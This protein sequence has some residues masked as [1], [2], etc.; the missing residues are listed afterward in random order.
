MV[1]RSPE[2]M[3]RMIAFSVLALG[4][5]LIAGVSVGVSASKTQNVKRIVQNA[6]RTTSKAVKIKGVTINVE[7]ADTAAAR[8]R[9]LSGRASLAVNRGMLFLFD[10]PDYYGFWMPNMKFNIDIVFI[11]DDKIVEIVENLPAP[12]MGEE[13]ATYFPRNAADRVLEVNA[14]TAKVK[15]WKAGDAV[16][17]AGL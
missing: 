3:A 14:G 1:K 15:N 2:E 16:L 7:I 10:K 6:A 11:R 5:V 17:M 8:E 9:G 13:P 4:L 12:K